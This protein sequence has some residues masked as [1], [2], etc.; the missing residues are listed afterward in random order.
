MVDSQPFL[1]DD[2]DPIVLEDTTEKKEDEAP[3][4]ED[5]KKPE[6]ESSGQ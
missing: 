1:D 5:D 2:G 6:A 4:T 3:K